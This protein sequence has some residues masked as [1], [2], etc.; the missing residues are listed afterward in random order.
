MAMICLKPPPA[1][2]PMCIIARSVLE[3]AMCHQSVISSKLERKIEAYI[4][5]QK[6]HTG[7]YRNKKTGRRDI[8][9]LP[10]RST[11]CSAI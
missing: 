10:Q 6:H 9:Y 2:D 5:I 4:Y 7:I 11:I 3:F 1:S 8:K